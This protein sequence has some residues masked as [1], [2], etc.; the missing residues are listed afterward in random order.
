MKDEKLARHAA[1]KGE[2]RTAYRRLG[3]NPEW[4]IGLNYK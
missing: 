3:G 1:C 2:M 4:K